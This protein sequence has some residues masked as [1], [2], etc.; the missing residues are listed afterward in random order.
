MFNWKKNKKI[1]II[2]GVIVILIVVAMVLSPI[3]SAVR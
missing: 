2:A 1:Q 3:L